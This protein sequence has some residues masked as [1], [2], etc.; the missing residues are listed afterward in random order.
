MFDSSTISDQLDGFKKS[1]AKRE[2]SPSPDV[3]EQ[4]KLMNQKMKN[5]GKKHVGEY[6]FRKMIKIP[7]FILNCKF[8]RLFF[9]LNFTIAFLTQ[10]QWADLVERENALKRQK[11][12]FH[13]GGG[14]NQQLPELYSASRD[15]P[16]RRV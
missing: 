9:I 7:I 3:M 2:R 5:D 16:V 6:G 1:N 4:I 10:V 14:W 15:D 8:L 12:G 11:I 13:I